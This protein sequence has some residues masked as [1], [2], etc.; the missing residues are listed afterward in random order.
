MDAGW[1]FGGVF[2]FPSFPYA[3]RGVNGGKSAMQEFFRCRRPPGR[4]MMGAG[5][6]FS[7]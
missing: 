1:S 3:R 2:F 5:F 6:R 4:P 7:Q